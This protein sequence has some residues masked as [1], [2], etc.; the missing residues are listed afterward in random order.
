MNKRDQAVPWK[1]LI[2]PE[3]IAQAQKEIEKQY[4]DIF[5]KDMEGWLQRFLVEVQVRPLDILGNPP[6]RS[7]SNPDLL[8]FPGDPHSKI[9]GIAHASKHQRTIY[10]YEIVVA[11][12]VNQKIEKRGIS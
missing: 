7:F 11:A 5:R 8:Y 2:A 3:A 1:V 4:K 10:V 12:P 9:C 6:K